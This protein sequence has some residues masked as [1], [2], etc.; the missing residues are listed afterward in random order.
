VPGA[1]I[2]WFQV[3]GFRFKVEFQVQ[4]FRFKVEF[5]VQ[6]F[7]FKVEFR[8][9]SSE[10]SVL[11]S[12]FPSFQ[13]S[14]ALPYFNVFQTFSFRLHAQRFGISDSGIHFLK[15]TYLQRLTELAKIIPK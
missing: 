7:R 15:L 5:R 14:N 3:Q 11:R 1:G 8:V 9:L 2:D 6:G 4:G 10:F 12:Q 13:H